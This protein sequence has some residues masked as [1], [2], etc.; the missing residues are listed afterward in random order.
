MA[1][2]GI[3]ILAFQNF[4]PI[5]KDSAQ[6]HSG[7]LDLQVSTSLVSTPPVA[8]IDENLQEKQPPSQ[9]GRVH[10]Q[11]TTSNFGS[12]SEGRGFDIRELAPQFEGGHFLGANSNPI[13]NSNSPVSGNA[14]LSQVGQR[15]F[16]S[17]VRPTLRPI[18]DAWVGRI[19]DYLDRQ[20]SSKRAGFVPIDG[21]D[22]P[23]SGG[24]EQQGQDRGPASAPSLPGL[25]AGFP[26]LPGLPE[27]GGQ[28]D[29]SDAFSWR[30]YRPRDVRM[31]K[32]N[33]IS[34]AFAHETRLS[35]EIGSHGGKLRVSRPISPNSSI[36]LNHESQDNKNS[37]G[38]KLSW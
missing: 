23:E 10:N 2:T 16:E 8:A 28:E 33:E 12:G 9:L 26:G 6:H 37:L 29:E 31:T 30:T 38:F 17:E 24:D 32:A 36:D 5:P 34:V 7:E 22:W 21:E 11:S 27:E 25:P 19:N 15:L 18:E 1:I 20:F 14:D 35:Y 13:S 4:S 3:L